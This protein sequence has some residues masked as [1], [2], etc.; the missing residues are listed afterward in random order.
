MTNVKRRKVSFNEKHKQEFPHIVAADTDWK[1]KCIICGQIFSIQNKGRQDIIQHNNTKTHKTS[2][3][4]AASSSKISSFL[5]SHDFQNETKQLALHELVFSYH[6]VM[7]NHSFR[8]MDCTSNLIQTFYDKKF[9]CARSKSNAIIK[10][11]LFPAVKE[12][13]I[14]ELKEIHFVSILSDASNHKAEKLYPIAVQYFNSKYGVQVKLLN[15]S[16]IKGETSEIISTHMMEIIKC[17][18]LKDKVV[19]ISADNTNTNFGGL[20]RRGKE[21]IFCKIKSSLGRNIFGIGCNA[22]IV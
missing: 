19:G 16:T 11:V 15:L 7:H 17:N 9:S 21:N 13:L 22:H 14:A 5:R 2:E 4:A 3:N 1:V 10:N 18:N 6:Q 8:S 12:E 20:K